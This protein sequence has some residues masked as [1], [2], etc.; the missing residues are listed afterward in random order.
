MV[1][2][3]VRDTFFLSRRSTP[4]TE[5][6]EAVAADLLDTLR[7]NADRCVGMAANMIGISCRVIAFCD[8]GDYTVMYNP[9]ILK[10]SLPNRGGVPVAGRCA[11]YPAVPFD[12]GA[13]SKRR[14]AVAHQ[15]LHRVDGTDHSTRAGSSGRDYYLKKRGKQNEPIGKRPPAKRGRTA[16]KR[17]TLL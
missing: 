17:N 16:G 15:N 3:I 12:Q 6:D 4:A 13:V 7:A 11:P 10:S 1:K 8:N 2:P 9:E 5:A 14:L